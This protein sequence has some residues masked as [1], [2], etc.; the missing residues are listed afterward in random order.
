MKILGEVGGIMR[1]LA[2][3]SQALVVAATLAGVLAIM[4]LYRTE[5]AVLRALGAT[6]GYVFLVIWGYVTLF[7]LG[8]A[9]LGL[10]LG[11]LVAIGV[12][13]AFT[14]DTGIALLPHGSAKR[15]SCWRPA[16]SPSARRWP[17]S[18]PG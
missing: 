3:A 16:W 5:L 1:F 12:S 6:R 8:G 7:V 9:L 15:S 11:V 17:S 14:A 2:L 18:P 10:A 4:E 13:A